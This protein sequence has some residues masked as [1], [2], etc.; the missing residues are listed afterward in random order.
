M[1]LPTSTEVRRKAQGYRAGFPLF[2]FGVVGTFHDDDCAEW[3]FLLADL[4]ESTEQRGELMLSTKQAAAL[5]E[6]PERFLNAWRVRG[7]GPTYFKV[8]RQIRY[9]HADLKSWL[10]AQEVDR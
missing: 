3:L 9:R 6:V 5:L 7:T 1:M 10:Q 8:G 2:Q 4:L